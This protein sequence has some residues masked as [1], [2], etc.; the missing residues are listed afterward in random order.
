MSTT[1]S[2]TKENKTPILLELW[3]K[4]P[5]D[6]DTHGEKAY[7]TCDISLTLDTISSPN[8]TGFDQM[9]ITQFYSGELS[10]FFRLTDVGRRLLDRLKIHPSSPRLLSVTIIPSDVQYNWAW[11]VSIFDPP[12]D[13]REFVEY[14]VKNPILRE[15]SPLCIE[16][17]RLPLSGASN[18]HISTS[19]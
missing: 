4:L 14:L 11:F 9:C 12:K 16:W 19:L 7:S 15:V 2:E 6:Y 3:K 17:G 8:F 13:I 10:V 18:L 1:V 5:Y